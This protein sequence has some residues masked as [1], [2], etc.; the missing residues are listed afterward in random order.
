MDRGP[1]HRIFRDR[2]SACGQ[3]ARGDRSDAPRERRGVAGARGRDASGARGAPRVPSRVAVPAR[4]VHARRPPAHGVH[5]HLR[6]GCELVRAAL[7]PRG[8][9]QLARHR[10]RRD[11]SDGHGRRV[12]L[13][14]RRHH[15]LVPRQRQVHAAPAR[16]VQRR[17]CRHA[18]RRGDHAA[19][20]RVG[21]HAPPR[22]PCHRRGAH[23][24]WHPRRRIGGRNACCAHGSGLHAARARALARNRHARRRRPP[25]RDPA[26]RR[27]GHALAA[28][29]PHAR[30]GRRDHRRAGH[31]FHHQASRRRCS[32]PCA[33]AVPPP[34]GACPLQRLRRRAP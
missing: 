26:H 7:R 8:R 3:D 27:A 14:R 13:L 19:R 11:A 17:A 23:R 16:C 25:A 30:G 20:H 32:Q 9:A 10:R 28:L 31:L 33:G 15:L 6:G 21:R 18:A 22:V 29:P 4:V 24:A 12:P 2:A 1:E 34:R 5:V